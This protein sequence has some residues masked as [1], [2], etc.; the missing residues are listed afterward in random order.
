MKQ[1]KN[2]PRFKRI[3]FYGLVYLTVGII[4]ALVTNP[5]ESGGMQTALRL[6]ALALAI[7]AFVYHI[8]L[9]L[10]QSN[11]SIPKA[12]LNASIATAFGT[13]LLAILAN[14]YGIITEADN[15]NQLLLALILWP[16]V[17]GLLTFL[18]GYVIS[19]IF[20]LIR[21]RRK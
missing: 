10:F 5:L 7:A 4:S 20:S 8:R 13:F 15:K 9:E 21:S 18:G 16:V 12:S 1:T 6:L 11:N 19:K 2:N 14:I 17:T 3:I